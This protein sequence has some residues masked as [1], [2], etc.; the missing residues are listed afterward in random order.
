MDH[1]NIIRLYEVFESDNS[2]QVVM[3]YCNG[4]SIIEF[5][6]RRRVFDENVIRIILRQLIGCLNYL[7]SLKIVHRDI[8]LENIVFID[9]IR[10]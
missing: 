5:I 2:Y 9:K 7:H 6:K 3:E 8:K 1:P 10:N 4:G